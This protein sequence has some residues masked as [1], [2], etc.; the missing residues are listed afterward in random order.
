MFLTAA[1]SKAS[2]NMVD[3]ADYASVLHCLCL[4]V[5]KRSRFTRGE[6]QQKYADDSSV[7]NEWKSFTTTPSIDSELK[8]CPNARTSTVCRWPTEKTGV[9]K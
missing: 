3:S 2:G 7:G 1:A 5:A 9:N 6:V 8:Y 4:P